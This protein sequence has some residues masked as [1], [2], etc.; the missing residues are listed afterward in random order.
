MFNPSLLNQTAILGFLTNYE[1]PDILDADGDPVQ[2]GISSNSGSAFITFKTS[3]MN[4]YS[5]GSL[6]IDATNSLAQ[7]GTYKIVFDLD[8]FKDIA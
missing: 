1:V 3:L 5:T 4:F 6:V 8:D 7:A 2:M